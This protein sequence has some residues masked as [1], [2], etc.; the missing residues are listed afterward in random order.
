MFVPD[1]KTTLL[2][3]LIRKLVYNELVDHDI[4]WGYLQVQLIEDLTSPV[5][6][7]ILFEGLPFIH[8]LLSTKHVYHETYKF[9]MDAGELCDAFQPPVS[10]RFLIWHPFDIFPISEIDDEW[11]EDLAPSGLVDFIYIDYQSQG[12]TESPFSMNDDHSQLRIH[13]WAEWF[14]FLRGQVNDLSAARLRMWQWGYALWDIDRIEGL[15]A[16]ERT[17]A[18]IDSLRRNQ[19]FASAVE[20]AAMRPD[21]WWDRRL[22]S[23]GLRSTIY[24][25]GGR[26]WC[27]AGNLRRIVWTARKPR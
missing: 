4:R 3:K 22:C 5:I 15:R 23:R 10:P 19:S 20:Q 21:R 7:Y 11:T 18:R 25:H 13:M 26:G 12:R 14:S 24:E 9:F 27:E 16:L 8:Q 2:S 6:N 17:P 1:L